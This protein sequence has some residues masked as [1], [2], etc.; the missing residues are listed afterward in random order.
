MHLVA[1]YEGA[2]YEVTV[3]LPS[4]TTTVGSLVSSWTGVWEAPVRIDGRSIDQST[5]LA[6]AA[7]RTGS[8]VEVGRYG[9]LRPPAVEAMDVSGT[10]NRPP[11][12][13]QRLSSPVIELPSAAKEQA[14]VSRFSWGGLV[15]PIVL[16]I[17]MAVIVHPRMAMFAFFSPAMLVANWLEDRR[18]NR[19]ERRKSREMLS[20]S[21]RQLVEET[22]AA[23]EDEAELR[24]TRACSP[25]ELFRRAA[26]AHPRLWERRADHADFMVVP[27]GTGCPPW[28]PPWHGTLTAEA[29]VE[30][31]R[32]G[33]IHDVPE[34]IRL[35]PGQVAGIAARRAPAL[36]TARHLVIQAAV[37][38]GPSDLAISIVTERAAD[39]DWAKWLPHTLAD[40]AGRRRLAACD[41]EIAGVVSMLPDGSAEVA[42]PRHLVVVD[43]PNLVGGHRNLIREKLRDGKKLG[44]AALALAGRIDDLPSLTSTVLRIEDGGS[45]IRDSDGE[46]RF[47]DPWEISA[48]R[49][50][51]TARALSRLDD[52]ESAVSSCGLPTEIHLPSLIGLKSGLDDAIRRS[53]ARASQ[54]LATPIGLGEAGPMSIDL[55]ADG[56]HALL[57]GTTGSGKS[58]LLRTLVA[59]LAVGHSPMALNFVLIDYKGGSAFDACAGFPHTVG[60][61]T[62]LD[63][64]L[65][66]RALTCLGAELRYRETMLRCAGVSN[67][68]EF[69]SGYGESLPRL[70]VVIDE[71]AALAK[72]LPEFLDALLGIAQRG[73]S[74]GVHLLL[75]TQRPAGVITEG[76]KANTNLRIA[77]RMQDVA[78]SV[79][80][81]GSD[82]AAQISRVH[83]GRAIARLGPE[84]VRPF[85]TAVVTGHSIGFGSTSVRTTPFEFALEPRAPSVE[86]ADVDGPTD[87][88]RIVASAV[89]VAATLEFA[90][91]RL[92][93]P[94]PLQTTV[95]LDELPDSDLGTVF[96]L[97]DEPHRQR[98]VG[99][100]WSP[101]G[102]N[103]SLYGLPGSGTSTAL[104]TLATGLC[105]DHDPG[106][107]HL[108]VLDFDDQHLE[109]L[110]HL[111]HV[112][113]VVGGSERERQIRLLR[114][115]A[116]ELQRRRDRVVAESAGVAEHPVIVTMLDNYA[117]FASCFDSPGDTAIR[118]LLTRLV[119]DG[120]GVG[121][122]SIIAAKQPS[123][124][125]PRLASLFGARL[126]FRLA[127]RYEYTGLGIAAVD[128]P[129]VPGRA[130]ESGTGRE[131][132]VAIPHREGLEAAVAG[133]S[134]DHSPQ[135]PWSIG[136]L[137]TE[138]HVADFVTSG[139]ISAGEWFLPVGI[140]DTALTPVGLL[141]REGEHALVT[142]PARSGKS[143]ALAT[144]A[145]VAR[146]AS[147]RVRISAILSRRSPLA[148]SPAVDVI[149]ELEALA[150][151]AEVDG[152]HLLLVDDAELIED[153]LLGRLIRERRPGIRVVA[154]GSADALRSLYGHWTQ[155]IRRSR[156]GCALRPN[157]VADG[158]L[159]QTPLPRRGPERFP[160]GRGY[161]LCDGEVEL[162]QLG[163]Y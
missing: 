45:W 138:V 54:G 100:A 137:P 122:L 161:L 106:R 117:A 8:V 22:A 11:R 44:I 9:D 88:E 82:G 109:P 55:V 75:A 103:L 90:Q 5:P 77:L 51:E 155:D 80:V 26:S 32:F 79:D 124:V 141:L 34:E 40:D 23:R 93:W 144:L 14:R 31:A 131:I 19:K 47:L 143:T 18:R 149:L 50:R 105:A 89:R 157:V 99:A 7:L 6:E 140:G 25:E 163:R 39:W 127:D 74:L 119:A 159:W 84:D 111:P 3:D 71:F 52:P 62:D 43:L 160:A 150:G 85:Q 128:P 49:A 41:D 63:E 24:R 115:L 95:A 81:V 4:G 57:G 69:D 121:M 70:V 129:T 145:A 28:R 56:P 148:E 96:G 65:A 53:W 15:V 112:G 87:L 126:G 30:L 2:E 68:A 114:R 76:I 73:R 66:E 61:V 91:P 78:D 38:Q 17:A 98:Q 33:E 37:N 152:P 102:G 94:A 158:D 35:V 83:P 27:V 104:A 92:P 60:V 125:P 108:Y 64:H 42:S 130:F 21:L 58:E 154:A 151:L 10:F 120:P 110:L 1:R 97:A 107:L 101:A 86:V 16:G 133:M 48:R 134:W 29:R 20:R 118:D 162:V 135:V 36:A 72:E 146:N 12:V 123:D 153:A 13:P 113:A 67:I 116:D 59:G 147:P 139:H 46:S 156:A 142:G 132:Q 136:V